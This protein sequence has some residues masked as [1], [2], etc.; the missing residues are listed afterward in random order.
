MRSGLRVMLF[1]KEKAPHV[2]HTGPF[3]LAVRRKP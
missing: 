3:K 1:E 2:K